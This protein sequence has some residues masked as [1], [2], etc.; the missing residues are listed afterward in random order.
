MWQRAGRTQQNAQRWSKPLSVKRV[1]TKS[2]LLLWSSPQRLYFKEGEP[3]K[4]GTEAGQTG[5]DGERTDQ[6][7]VHPPQVLPA[8]GPT[9]TVFPLCGKSKYDVS[10]QAGFLYTSPIDLCTRE[11]RCGVTH[12]RMPC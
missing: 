7:E 5:K 2:V 9:T 10:T 4:D 11:E 8:F 3:G 1:H 12:V 6:K